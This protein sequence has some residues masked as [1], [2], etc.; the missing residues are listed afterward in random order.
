MFPDAGQAF[1]NV[2]QRLFIL[3]T[4]LWKNYSVL[5]SSNTVREQ[6]TCKNT[7]IKRKAACQNV[8]VAENKEAAHRW[9]SIEYITLSFMLRKN[10]ICSQSMW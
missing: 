3:R 7:E 9:F 10:A 1:K 8:C 2:C 6:V 5:T 4:E